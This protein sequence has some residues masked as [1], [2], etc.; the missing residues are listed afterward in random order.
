MDGNNNI[1][2]RRSR[3]ILSVAQ[4]YVKKNENKIKMNR[5]NR[6]KIYSKINRFKVLYGI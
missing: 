6:S 5:P 4:K 2:R 3:N 1:R